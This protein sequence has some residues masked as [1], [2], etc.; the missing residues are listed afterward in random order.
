M[1]T[2]LANKDAIIAG[3]EADRVTYQGM[4]AE[5]LAL[6]IWLSLYTAHIFSVVDAINKAKE[7]AENV[8]S[9]DRLRDEN[10]E[11]NKLNQSMLMELNTA[12][13]SL[14]EAEQALETEKQKKIDALHEVQDRLDKRL[15]ES[16][17]I[18]SQLLSKS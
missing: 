5:P 3:F 2:E 4:N 15:D 9:I 1:K 10:I 16:L 8:G 17:A 7:F 13:E 14:L 12:K 6:C 18:D 11:L